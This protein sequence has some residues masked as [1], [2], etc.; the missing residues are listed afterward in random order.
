M[1]AHLHL[2]LDYK[3]APS[4]AHPLYMV[5]SALSVFF[6]SSRAE[7]TT[8]D[9]RRARHTSS[10]DRPTH[11]TAQQAESAR[12]YARATPS[13]DRATRGAPIAAGAGA[14]PA[15]ACVRACVRGATRN[16][17]VRRGMV[18]SHPITRNDRKQGGVNPLQGI[19]QRGGEHSYILMGALSSNGTSCLGG[20][21]GGR[22]TRSKPQG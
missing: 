17:P 15:R 10:A 9:R 1:R 19:K 16:K 8:R 4:H 3:S 14:A 22:P 7:K 20:Y 2:H 21:M 5:H 6:F 12:T 11:S 18:A 13:T